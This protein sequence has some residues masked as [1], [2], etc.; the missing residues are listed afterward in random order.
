MSVSACQRRGLTPPDIQRVG[1]RGV[2]LSL[3]YS[4]TRCFSDGPADAYSRSGLRTL[5]S[6]QQLALLDSRLAGRA[7]IGDLAALGP[8]K[9]H[10]T[11]PRD[12]EPGRCINLMMMC[13][14]NITDFKKSV[15]VR[16][17]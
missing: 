2:V 4:S 14:L 12:G 8:V 3:R 17:A 9:V 6:E 5:F 10:R 16:S 7:G 15:R 1:L 13:A 11:R